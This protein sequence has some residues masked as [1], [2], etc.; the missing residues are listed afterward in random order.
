MKLWILAA[1]LLVGC[2]SSAGPVPD[3]SSDGADSRRRAPQP[4]VGADLVIDAFRTRLAF[5]CPSTVY[6][7]VLAGELQAALA[8][9]DFSRHRW[10]VAHPDRLLVDA[11]VNQRMPDDWA[12]EAEYHRTGR[13]NWEICPDRA[14]AAVVVDS[15]VWHWAAGGTN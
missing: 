14:F 11:E 6:D 9:P 3:S 2:G 15:N 8:E 10:D 7:D 12:A 4:E 1:A 13:V 5:L